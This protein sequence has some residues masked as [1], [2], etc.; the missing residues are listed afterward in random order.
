[1]LRGNPRPVHEV[2][3][4]PGMDPSPS[5]RFLV[6]RASPELRAS[7]AALARTRS[8]SAHRTALAALARGVAVLAAE[9][10]LGAE[11]R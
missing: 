5:P 3:Y 9:E 1:M 8:A 10:P 7:L 6:L 2:C 4:A 11:V